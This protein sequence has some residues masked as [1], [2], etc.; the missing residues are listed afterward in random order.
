MLLWVSTF[1]CVLAVQA[2]WPR[3]PL[4]PAPAE[5][6]FCLGAGITDGAVADASSAGRATTCAALQ[7]A[8]V[9]PL[10]L[11]TGAGVPGLSA[12][13]A[14]ADIARE[15]GVADSAV[16]VEPHARSTLQ[17]AAF[18]LALLPEPPSRVLVVSDAFHLPRAWVIF[19]VL[20]VPE[21]AL[22]ATRSEVTPDV[23]TMLRWCLR[24][25][26]AIW[27]NVARLG[28]Y[29]AAGTLGIDRET[30]IGWFN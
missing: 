7:A 4:D 8:G 9:A 3:M 26:V 13:E 16:L 23:P 28:V 21:V 22:R 1:L 25:S 20:G 12:A 2:F 29:A 10:L 15:A 27:F 19:H 17:N 5:V 30:R 18:G 11:F 6:I 24:E 14:M